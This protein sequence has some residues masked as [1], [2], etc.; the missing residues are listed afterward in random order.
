M[1]NIDLGLDHTTVDFSAVL[2][3]LQTTVSHLQS[4]VTTLQ[5]TIVT[6]A[7]SPLVLQT[8]PSTQAI[9]TNSTITAPNTTQ[10]SIQ[11]LDY[12]DHVPGIFY[13]Q[14]LSGEAWQPIYS[15][16]IRSKAI[17]LTTD[18][19]RHNSNHASNISSTRALDERSYHVTNQDVSGVT[20]SWAIAGHMTQ[21]IPS[22]H[23]HR[24]T[25]C[26]ARTRPWFKFYVVWAGRR[27]GI[28]TTWSDCESQV[29]RYSGAMYQG[30]HTSDQAWAAFALGWLW[31]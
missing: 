14:T 4:A 13:K 30:F 5:H 17:A 20:T 26:S 27:P 23:V 31:V 12:P 25:Q 18:L 19:D 28:Y 8:Q 29:S 1:Q 16:R 2:A 22:A 10:R 6:L 21:G 11:S 9:A 15:E 24:I 3:D 7:S